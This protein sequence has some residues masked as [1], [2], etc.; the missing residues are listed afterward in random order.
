MKCALL[1]Q[2][3]LAVSHQLQK[4]LVEQ[5]RGLKRVIV[6]LRSHVPVSN[7][8]KRGLYQGK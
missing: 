4:R 8:A 5:G 2:S 7:L 6:P 1:C 3:G